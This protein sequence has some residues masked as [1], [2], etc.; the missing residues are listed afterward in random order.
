MRWF[1]TLNVFLLLV[2]LLPLQAAA[3]PAAPRTLTYVESSGGLIPPELEGG[4]TE[5]EMGDVNG[6]GNIDLVSIGDHGSPYVNTDEHG[7]M[8]WFGD[9]AGNW[10]VYQNGAFG[11]GGVALGDVNGDGL[12]DVGYAMH[13]NY[14]GVDFGDQLIEVALGDGTGQN[15]TPWDD[16]LATNG[17]TWGMFATDFLDV[18]ADGDLDVA[19][20]SFGCCAGLHVYLNQGDGS[21]GQSFGFL[22]G[23][24]WTGMIASGD[25]NGDGA[26]DLAV[27]HELGSVYL[28]DGVGGFTLDDGNLPPPGTRGRSGAALGDVDGDGR[29][30]FAFCNDNGGVEVWDW[31]GLGVW[32]DMS[33]SLPSSGPYESAQLADMDVDGHVDVAAFGNGQL[34]IWGG[35]GAGGWSEIASLTTPSPGYLSAFRTGGDADHN[36]YPDLAIVSEEGT[37]PSSQ[38]HLHF[39]KESST[40]TVLR[41]T[42]VSPYGHEAY[43]AGAVIFVDWLSAV[44]SGAPGA[45]TLELSIHGPGG[46]WTT[47]ATGLPDNGRYQWRIPPNTPST[48]DAYIRYTLSVSPDV[49]TSL[50]PAPFTILGIIE[51]PIAGLSAANDSPTPLGQ[52]TTLTATVVSGTN[53]LYGWSFGDGTTGSGAQ[54]Q[55]TYPALGLYT[56]TVTASNSLGALSTT[57]RVTITEAPVAGLEAVSDSPTVL[58]QPTS[59]TATVESGSN[60]VYEWSFGDGASGSGAMVAHT[61][62]SVGAYAATV[63]A[64]N[65][66]NLLTATVPVLV[67]VPLSGLQAESDSPTLLSRPTAFTATV[68]TGTDVVYEWTFGDGTGGAGGLVAH[69]YLAAGDYTATVTASNA[70]SL[71]TAE[72]AVLVEEPIAG[73][74]A[75][76]DGPTALGQAT[77]LTATIISGTNV[78][79]SWALGDGSAGSGAV[80]AHNYTLSGLY[81]AT[82]TASNVVSRLT[83]TTVVLVQ[84]PIA[85]LMAVSDSP[86]ALGQ[87]TALTA[88]VLT[89]TEVAYS[90]SFGDGS[91]AGGAVVTHTY[92]APT[93]YTVTVTASNAVSLLTATLPVLVEEPITGL[94]VAS[95]SPTLLGS[96]T[97]LT[98]TLLTGTNVTFTWSF[99]DGTVGWGAQAVH[100]YAA[101]GVYTA[102]VTARNAVGEVRAETVVE[103]VG[104]AWRVYLPMITKKF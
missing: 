47:L 98:A 13:H 46:P 53:V 12:M 43:R 18:D 26:P 90:W 94:Q 93:F 20:L 16:G 38:N 88:T 44:P 97:H 15:W 68:V 22:G 103:V 96:L 33:G 45:V 64:S 67:Q 48:N 24:N 65:P 6:D 34:R 54:V 36:G 104:Q 27:P 75:V 35:D 66:L 25:V 78:A 83:A 82:V 69:T 1:A 39:Y 61:Y 71:L 2:T 63:T 85:G 11:Y 87:A 70:V 57:T 89:G 3:K 91:T 19:S 56:A 86:T 23:N 50:T 49:T 51:E 72:V 59:F 58:G 84:E 5:I 17:E 102:A 40:P 7:I 28:G 42:P 79:Y 8:V 101:T 60:L 92:P 62:P 52:M 41:I 10:S 14:S 100:S 29:D 31:T 74:V 30:E 76:N 77:A 37:W 81:T 9:G 21:W 55:H 32:Q 80:V 4:N 73:L 99:G 95:D